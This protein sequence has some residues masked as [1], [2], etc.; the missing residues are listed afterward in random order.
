MQQFHDSLYNV[1]IKLCE[2]NITH[3]FRWSTSE[4]KPP[5]CDGAL[6]VLSKVPFPCPVPSLFNKV[7]G[8]AVT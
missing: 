1:L 3:S 5:V 8:V 7:N 6:S 2:N 4:H